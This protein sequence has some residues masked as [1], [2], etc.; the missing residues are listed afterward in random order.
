MTYHVRNTDLAGDRDHGF[1]LIELLVVI[2][3][4]ALL[5]GILLPALGAARRSAQDLKCSSN[6]HQLG[7]GLAAYATDNDGYYPPNWNNG[8]EADWRFWY[9]DERIGQYMPDSI[10]AGTTN[11]TVGGGGFVCPRDEYALRSYSMNFWGSSELNFN[12]FVEDGYT[13]KADARDATKVLLLADTFS[14]WGN[15]NDG[16]FTAATVG[17]PDNF[18]DP[19]AGAIFGGDPSRTVPAYSV[20]ETRFGPVHSELAYYRHGSS[21]SDETEAKGAVNIAYVDGHVSKKSSSDL[22]DETTG[23]TTN[24]TYWLPP[25]NNKNDFIGD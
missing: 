21:G 3:I 6:I 14:C 7:I 12:Q 18:L 11:D 10:G 8:P 25:A 16:W 9:D 17:E 13:F 24:D 20:P 19:S 23:E 22:F 1:T 5:V 15:E 2:S 4:I